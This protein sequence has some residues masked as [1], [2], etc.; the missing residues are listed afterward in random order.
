MKKVWAKRNGFTI[1]ELLV[2]IVILGILVAISV[3]A[4]NGVQT[5]ARVTKIE[6]DL[7]S[8][9]KLV[10]SYKA[11]NGTYPITAASLNLD[12]STATAKT[13]SNCS[14]GTHVSEW[15]PG[16]S[17]SLPQ[18]NSTKGVGGYPGCYVYVSDGTSYVLSA[19]NM[20]ESPQTDTMYRRLGFREM[21]PAH[22]NQFYICNHG[23][24]GGVSGSYSI[25]ND[26]YKR[27]MTLTN[28][29]SALCNETPPAG[30]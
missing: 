4:Y 15:V 6:T 29:T 24:I 18:S 10:E 23:A 26:Y 13:D 16:L 30:A 25:N 20:L 17:V 22:N 7:T 19:W 14:I 28:I 1:T 11:R 3:V 2:V 21:D 9:Q 12:W 5:R 27:S 8:V